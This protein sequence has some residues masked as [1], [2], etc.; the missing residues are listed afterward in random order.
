MIEGVG[1]FLAGL[2]AGMVN[3]ILGDGFGRSMR[4][5]AIGLVATRVGEHACQC[6]SWHRIF[7]G[8]T[9]LV[10]KVIHL[11]DNTIQTTYFMALMLASSGPA[12]AQ[13]LPA[14][15]ERYF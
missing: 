10:L 3:T 1:L 4:H 7:W 15:P 8:A 11:M 5:W 14:E 13:D 6:N 9:R 2:L 12:L